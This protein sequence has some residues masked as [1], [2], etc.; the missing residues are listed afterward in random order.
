MAE[1]SIRGLEEPVLVALKE[2][3]AKESVSVNALIV[4]LLEQASGVRPPS[5]TL[6]RYHDLDALFGT[7]T[8]EEAAEF[9]ANTAIFNEIDPGMWKAGDDAQ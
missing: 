7:W 1:I 6:R 3:A 9:E 4:R 8:E 2:Q 5:T